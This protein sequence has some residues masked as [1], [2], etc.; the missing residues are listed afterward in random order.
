MPQTLPRA[1]DN[2]HELEHQCSQYQQL[3]QQQQVEQQYQQ[4]RFRYQYP[5]QYNNV[6]MSG[7]IATS[8]DIVDI[9]ADGIAYGTAA[10]IATGAIG[11]K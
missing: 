1:A 10:D 4:L 8:I 9:I 11:G 2:V 6:G 5:H 7:P 3:Q